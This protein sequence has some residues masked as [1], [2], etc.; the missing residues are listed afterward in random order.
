MVK[1]INSYD[2][3]RLASGYHTG[4]AVILR[5]GVYYVSTESG[6][7]RATKREIK[8]LKSNGRAR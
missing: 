3:T 1:I 4:V 7:R 5:D 6:T 2:G 8:T